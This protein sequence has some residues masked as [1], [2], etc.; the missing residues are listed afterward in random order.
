M[1]AMAPCS[2]R[3]PNSTA[4][5]VQHRVVGLKTLVLIQKT[6]YMQ[7][8]S[9]LLSARLWPSGRASP[10][11]RIWLLLDPTRRLA[12]R[13]LLQSPLD[14]RPTTLSHREAPRI[15]LAILQLRPSQP[16]LAPAFAL[17]LLLSPDPRHRLQKNG[18]DRPS[19]GP[20]LRMETV[21]SPRK[22]SNPNV[23][24]LQAL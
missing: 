7:C 1:L 22:R 8:R 3:P 24:P 11:S 16:A 14:L 15:F 2:L 6:H 17:L 19:P 18:M 20:P 9:R 4:S 12:A 5:S 10:T 21:L 23:C 13:S